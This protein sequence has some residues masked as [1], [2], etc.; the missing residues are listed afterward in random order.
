MFMDRHKKIASTG[1]S[2]STTSSQSPNI[3]LLNKKA[4]NVEFKLTN[5]EI[6]RYLF[7]IITYVKV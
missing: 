6:A 3:A 5:T 1:G 4:E 7:L 2:T